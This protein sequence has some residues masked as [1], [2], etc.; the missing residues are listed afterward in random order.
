MLFHDC[1]LE[2]TSLKI[3]GIF[4]HNHNVVITPNK[5]KNNSLVSSTTQ[6]II[7]IPLKVG[8]FELG[9]TNYIEL[10]LKFPLIYVNLLHAYLSTFHIF[11]NPPLTYWREEGSHP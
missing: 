6:S 7:K 10:C 1:V 4:L 3:M 5:I 11:F 9:L 8:L 2:N